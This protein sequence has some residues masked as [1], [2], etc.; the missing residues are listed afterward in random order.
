MTDLS[1]IFIE[2]VNENMVVADNG[3]LR[4]AKGTEVLNF[5]DTKVPAMFEFDLPAGATSFT[6]EVEGQK[7]SQT[8]P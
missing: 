2:L 5:R 6:L 1:E 8:I 3:V 4:D 7:F